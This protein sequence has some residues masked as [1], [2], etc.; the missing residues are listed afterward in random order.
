MLTTDLKIA[1][2]NARVLAKREKKK[3]VVFHASTTEIPLAK[4]G[5]CPF[6]EFN[7][8]LQYVARGAKREVLIDS[9]IG[10]NESTK[11]VFVLKD[12]KKIHNMLFDKKIK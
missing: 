5:L 7:D 2:N 1:F 12:K 3:Y 4:A 9:I 6:E 10:Y 11:S 8:N